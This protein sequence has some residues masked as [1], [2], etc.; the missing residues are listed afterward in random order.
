VQVII[1][2]IVTP[3]GFPLAYEVL[4][5]NTPDKQTLTDAL[6]KIEAQYGKAERIRVMDRGIPTEETLALIMSLPISRPGSP[7]Q[8]LAQPFSG[9]RS[10]AASAARSA[11]QA[12]TRSHTNRSE[13][14]G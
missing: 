13:K 7:D 9:A 3:D 14:Y 1:A 8:G 4:A 12:L 11:G 10:R 6:A 2:L 5:G